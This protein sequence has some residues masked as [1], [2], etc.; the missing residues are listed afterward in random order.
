[1][2]R[3]WVFVHIV[4]L[5]G[6]LGSHGVSMV[7]LFQLRR[8][9]DPRRIG[10]L[11]ALSGSSI[12][13]FYVSLGVLLLGGV[14]A[15]FMGDWWG[16]AWIWAAIV[17]LVGSSIVMLVVARPYYRRVGLVARAMASGSHAVSTEQLDEVLLGPRP[18]AIAGIGFG[19]ILLILY[20]M[21]FKPSL[22]FSTAGGEAPPAP[23][24]GSLAISATELEFDTS[25]LTAPAGRPFDIVFDNTVAVPHNVAIYTDDSAADPLFVGETVTGPIAITYAVPALDP[26]EYFFRCDVHPTQMT[27]TL[28]A[29]EGG[30]GG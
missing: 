20:L 23:G 7:V 26:G 30:G 4:G 13:P 8:E 2:Y 25:S 17:L 9:R 19:A 5:L 11:L 29:E 12:R 16:Y 14:V 6:F 3:F 24:P 21:M 1:V 10:D 18:F 22:G 28:V 15:A 27:G